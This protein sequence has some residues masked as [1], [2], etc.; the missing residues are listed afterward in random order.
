MS[1]SLQKKYVYIHTLMNNKNAS[2]NKEKNR[3]KKNSKGNASGV[4]SSL[5]SCLLDLLC[6]L[7]SH[8]SNLFIRIKHS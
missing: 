2:I 6:L 5:F 8:W 1:I 7:G 3:I 4:G